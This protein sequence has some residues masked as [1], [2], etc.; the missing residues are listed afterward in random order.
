[1]E[2]LRTNTEQINC[3]VPESLARSILIEAVAVASHSLTV[4][5]IVEGLHKVNELVYHP[6][7][8]NVRYGPSRD[9]VHERQALLR[10]MTG[11]WQCH[12]R[13]AVNTFIVDE[14]TVATSV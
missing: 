2:V 10:I 4:P 3:P 6:Q 1:M 11:K 9:T 13:K 7:L 5:P 12:D 14:T 8:L